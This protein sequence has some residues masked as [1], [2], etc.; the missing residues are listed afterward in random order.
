MF[1]VSKLFIEGF[2]K[3]DGEINIHGAKNSV[4]PI[5]ASTILCKGDCIINN[6]PDLSD[7][8]VSIKIL[9]HLGAYVK[10]EKNTLIVNTDPIFRY[11]IPD[12]LMREM[13]S[14][15]IFLGAIVARFKE[16]KLSFPGGCE[17]GP[18][19]ID[20]HLEAF[21][22]MKL[23]IN[24]EH[25]FLD[26]V[27]K[28]SLQGSDINLS[29]PSVGATENI[30]LAA[31]LAKGKT[32]INNAAREPEICDLS[33]FLNKCG[34]HI[35]GAGEGDITIYGVNSLFG[36]EH[37]IIPDRI[38]AATFMS[39]A[40]AT[41]GS[42][43][44]RNVVPDH[45]NSII[46]IFEEAG[47]NISV[48]KDSIKLIAP[49]TIKPVKF[50]RTM[51]YPGFPTDAQAPIMAMLSLADGN[52]MFIEN[53]FDSRYKHVD[54]LTRMGANIKVEGK[55]AVVEGVK[56][57][58]GADVNSTDLRGAAALVVAGLAAEGSTY[59]T[60]LKHI[61][62]GYEKIEERLTSIGAKVKRI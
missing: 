6:C 5:L 52:S 27:V 49:S 18:R 42:I 30:M 2:S 48:Y 22:K 38:A 56:K 29:F 17:L 19:P 44:V 31:S 59:I 57:L 4:L 33:D 50:I 32:I 15:I 21:K 36:S 10:R 53:I 58:F 37:S 12:L 13:R 20:L 14:S 40:I 60:N 39:A 54:E 35:R 28:N 43:V 3:L 1:E 41:K 51:P 45:L 61:D 62:R 24:E 47:G 7:V 46:P 9:R 23:T 55:V 11:D 8:N 34:A 26:C 25:G 16:A